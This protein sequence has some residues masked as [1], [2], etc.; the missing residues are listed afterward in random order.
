MK[1]EN[2][3]HLTLLLAAVLSGASAS[4]ASAQA[5]NFVPPLALETAIRAA[6]TNNPE[7]RV[8]AADIASA[9][10]EVTTAKTWQNPEVSIA[11]GFKQLR[12][13]SDTQF[14]G[15]FGLDQ[16]FEW[17]GK[18]ALRRAV[19]EKNVAVRQLALD[20][21]RSQLAIQVRRAYFT[22][23]ATR[24]VVALRAQRLT[25][26]KTFVEAAKKKV[27]GGF[28]PEFEATKA[29]VEVVGAQ[30]MLRETQA[31]HDVARVALNSLMGRKPTEPLAVAGKLDDGIELPGQFALLERA[32]TQ[33]PAIKVQEAEAERTGLSLQSIRKSRLPDFKVGPSLEYTRDEQIVGFGLSLP[34]PFWDKKKGEIATATAEQEKAL[35][36]LDKLR[37]EILRDVTTASQNLAAAEESLAFYTP[38]L[39][40]KLKAA[41]DAAAQN[42]S[43]GRM[44]LLLYLEAQR[45]YFDTQAD[46]FE[47]LQKL[48]EAQAEVES[49]AGV[50]LDQLSQP[51]TEPK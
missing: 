40:D 32:L 47:M 24:E 28:A 27:E 3:C 15:N 10:G 6:W 23:L 4:P 50:S 1:R 43:E 31:Q 9:R 22:V 49:A 18:R 26:A 12:D 39:R 46:Y 5:A 45:T 37:R 2:Y 51:R 33:N 41:L 36:E 8:L 25:L 20:G 11:P 16:T 29:E 34:L 13:P 17:P 48:Y 19:A 7:I 35:A 38:A 21:F 42:Y 30:K 44:P 14:H